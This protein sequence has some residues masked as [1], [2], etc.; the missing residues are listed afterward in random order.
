MRG[1]ECVEILV[2]FLDMNIVLHPKH[3]FKA[4]PFSVKEILNNSTFS[5]CHNKLFHTGMEVGK[6]WQIR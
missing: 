1:E 6:L 2:D 3:L 4:F 5:F